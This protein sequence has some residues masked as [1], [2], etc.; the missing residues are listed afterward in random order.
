MDKYSL[1]FGN[2]LGIG[3]AGKINMVKSGRSPE[4]IY[5]MTWEELSLLFGEEQAEK[6]ILARKEA[7]L[8]KELEK[9]CAAKA[10][11][12]TYEEKD[13]PAR[14]RE[15]CGMPYGLYVRGQMPRQDLI[16][17]AIVGA[18]SATPY[19]K[20]IAHDIGKICGENNIQVISGL[21]RGVDGISQSGAME[22]GGTTFGVLGCGVD[23]CYPPGNLQVY[24]E[25]IKRG[26][27]ISEF[28]IG[29]KPLP[30]HFPSRNRIISGL[31]DIVVVVEAKKKSGSLITA[32]FALEQGRDVIAVPGRITDMTSEGCNHLISQ[33][34]EIY[35]GPETLER[36]LQSIAE[37]RN[38]KG[39]FN[40]ESTVKKNF[41]LTREEAIVFGCL[42]LRPKRLEEVLTECNLPMGEVMGILMDLEIKGYVKEASK[43]NYYV[44]RL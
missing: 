39:T 34:A 28:P 14:L 10:R 2:I 9:V 1:W 8:D 25:V 21:A 11:F 6:V 32:D 30:G 23:I 27:V 44:N 3:N 4:E 37:V 40:M 36:R 43:N 33:G 42:G 41:A 31:A 24:M 22:G 38:M 20:E 26:G 16:S 17:V 12:I 13:Y 29:T 19:G 35:M 15:L 18:R 7:D 5:H